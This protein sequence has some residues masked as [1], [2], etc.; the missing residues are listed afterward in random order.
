VVVLP[1]GLYYGHVT[2]QDAADLVTG[3]E[4]GRLLPA[5]LRGRSALLAPVQAAEH[6]A[7]QALGEYRL[8]ALRPLRIEPVEP[9]IWRIRL[10]H[11]AGPVTVTV[12][13]ERAG[14]PVR[15]TCSSAGPEVPRVF[16][17]VDLEL[18][19]STAGHEM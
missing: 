9:G 15:L 10:G 14:P 16:R 6:H 1:H 3:H 11:P 7:R 4:A 18:P 5:L 12:Q 17:L 2:P 13:A 19:D 8:D